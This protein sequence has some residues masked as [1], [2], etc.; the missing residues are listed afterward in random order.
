[1]KKILLVLAL[2]LI[3]IAGLIA[4]KANPVTTVKSVDL[5]RYL[6]KW[7]Q[8]AY[9]PNNFQPKDCGLTVAEYS[10]DRKGNII[11]KNTCYED[12]EGKKIK[13][14][15]TAKAWSVSKSNARLKVRFFWP[16]SGDYW[17]VRLDDDYQWSVVSDPSRKYLW[18]L[19]R[20][21][22]MDKD[23]WADMANWLISNGWQ[24]SRLQITGKIK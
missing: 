5:N 9:Y 15:A 11:V 12:A 6:G 17:I 4:K 2:A 18:V 8:I 19:A 22:T 7:Y 20:N 16:F 10:L 21:N 3:A 1:M 23:T 14:R 13:K 24:P